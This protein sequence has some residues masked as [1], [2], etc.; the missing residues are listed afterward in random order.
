[1]LY[2]MSG[3]ILLMLMVSIGA[4]SSTYIDRRNPLLRES[5]ASP[6]ALAQ[7]YFIRPR[8]ERT[9]GIADNRLS[10]EADRHHLLD[11][12]KG[13]YVLASMVPGNVWITVNSQTA[14]GPQGRIKKMTRSRQFQ[15]LAGETY[16]IIF[17]MV[18]GEFR[19]VYFKPESVDLST[20]RDLTRYMHAVGKARRFPITSLEG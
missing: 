19:G 1:M 20:A 16:F 13:E 10:V 12:A 15:F 9:M 6:A 17:S 3:L 7:V 11:I 14:W 8:T 5:V 2:R 4:C 18:D